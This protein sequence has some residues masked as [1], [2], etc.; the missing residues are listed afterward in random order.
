MRFDDLTVEPYAS[1]ALP[2]LAGAKSAV[3]VPMLRDGDL[4]GAIVIYRTSRDHSPTSRS[5]W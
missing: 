4:A 3:G 1:M 5:S 2:K